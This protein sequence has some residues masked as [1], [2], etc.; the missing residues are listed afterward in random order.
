L[1]YQ[2][3]LS[4]D[5]TRYFGW[6]VQKSGPSIQATL[7]SALEKVLN[8]SVAL[9]GSGRTDAGVHAQGQTAHFNTLRPIQPLRLQRALNAL[10]PLDI[11]VLELLPAPP[12]FH[13]RYSAA[14]KIYHYHLHLDSFCNP[15]TYPYRHRVLGPCDPVRMQKAFP[16]LLGTHDFSAFA[17]R[18]N[19]EAGPRGNVRTLHRLDLME[20]EGG[21][22]LEFEA[23]GFLYKMVRNM[24]GA[25]LRVG[26]GAIAPEQIAEILQAKRR[27]L[28]FKAAPPQG[29]FLYKVC[30]TERDS[31]VGR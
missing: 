28:P 30:Y 11:R 6:Q 9:T 24:T 16:Y 5:G 4:Y 17:N 8:H 18:T 29:L 19:K 21:V 31:K 2:L 27:S 7:Q 10:L 25:L 12:N 26:A 13:A 15:F 3:I 23:D 22:R 1:R 14:S 20:Q